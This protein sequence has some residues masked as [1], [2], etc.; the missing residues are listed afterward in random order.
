MDNKANG[1]LE[2]IKKHTAMD[3]LFFYSVLMR[4]HLEF[5]VQF[6]VPLFMK[7][8]ESR[9]SAKMIKSLEHLPLKDRLIALGLFGLEELEK[10]SYGVD[11][12]TRRSWRSFPN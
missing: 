2:C 1:I 6:W 9:R 7:Y 12:W 5:C 10:E 11:S 3:V 4:P 8:G